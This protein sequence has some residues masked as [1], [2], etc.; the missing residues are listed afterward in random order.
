MKKFYI[1]LE[2]HEGLYSVEQ[3][4]KIRE[5]TLKEKEI[6]YKLYKTPFNNIKFFELN[7]VK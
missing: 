2:I 5:F 4:I 1:I 3:K 6:Y 7:E